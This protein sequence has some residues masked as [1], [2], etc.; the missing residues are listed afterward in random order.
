MDGIFYAPLDL[1]FA[2]RS[3]IARL[4]PRVVIVAETE[5]WPNLFRQVKRSGAG[6]MMVNA[7]ISDQSLSSYRRFRFFFARVLRHADAILA[8]SSQ[9]AE[10]LVAIGAPA[11][12]VE[13]G[14]NLKY[15]FE[16]GETALPEDLRAL[17]DGVGARTVI[18]AGSTREDEEQPVVEAFRALA[19]RHKRALLVLAPRH[20]QRFDEV[21]ALL[22]RLGVRYRRR[23]ELGDATE[24]PLALPGVLLLDSLGELSSLY[25]RAD[26]VFVG[27][28]LNGWGGHNVLEPALS[29]RPV[30]VG[31]T[32]QNFREITEQ[33]LAAEGLAQVQGAEGLAAAFEQLVDDPAGADALGA[34]GRQVAEAQR[35]ATANAVGVADR[36][37]GE[38]LPREVPSVIARLAL[39]LPALAWGVAARARPAL[40]GR[41][42]WKS[43]RL[44]A[45]TVCVGN[46]TAGGAGKTPMV[47]WLAARLQERGYRVGILT[48]GYGRSSGQSVS[49]VETGG[50]PTVTETGDEV[51]LLLRQFERQ[52]VAVPVAIGADRYKAG[53]VLEERSSVDVLLMDDGFQ[54]VRLE[55]DFNL[56]L[57]DVTRPLS[58]M[59]PLGRLREPIAGAARADA[60]VLTRT[61]AGRSYGEVEHAL[62]HVN[63][64][65][66]VRRSRYRVAGVVDVKTGSEVGELA[67]ER[68]LGFCGLGNPDTFRRS[69]RELGE[70]GV[71]CLTFADHHRYASGD[72]ARIAEAAR[73][74]Q[75]TALVTS[76]KDLM[77]LRQLA[78]DGR[79]DR[80]F[81]VP[82]Y[83][84]RI[85]CEVDEAGE[86]VEAIVAGVESR[87]SSR[88]GAAERKAVAELSY[89]G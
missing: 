12:R 71:P 42:V 68:L 21:A 37:Y 85:E 56:L 38:A 57:V 75:A 20:P 77:N 40:Y 73:E 72:V 19:D 64:K 47:G 26:V 31:P 74:H 82:L 44:D 15:D 39:G 84:L 87:I 45:F 53:R 54:H 49:V 11:E 35:G 59:L 10:R 3:V 27:G 29:G 69:L 34:R 30:V 48:R 22:E 58:G 62:K 36:L 86:L 2:V 25:A 4:K 81:D 80:L 5:I 52:G 88:L 6:L 83:W 67:E 23:S 14:G 70:E 16:P 46:L 1:P 18:V 8:Q 24:K 61:D 9:D 50:K 76:E 43:R 28:S 63:P 65:A 41:G 89:S 32:M 55:R 78:A 60:I 7:R 13:A 33:L 17:L 51:Q 66:V 79:V